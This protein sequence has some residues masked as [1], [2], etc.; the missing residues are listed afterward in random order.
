MNVPPTMPIG[1]SSI[2]GTD[3]ISLGLGKKYVDLVPPLPAYEP[4]KRKRS[5]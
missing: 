2:E 4:R 5:E 1:G 3:F